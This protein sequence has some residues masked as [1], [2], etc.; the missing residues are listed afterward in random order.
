MISKS[1]SLNVFDLIWHCKSNSLQT[2]C[3][4]IVR[5]GV[6]HPVPATNRRE[7][8]RDRCTPW[9]GQGGLVV[10]VSDSK[11]LQISREYVYHIILYDVLYS[12][13][14]LSTCHNISHTNHVPSGARIV[15]KRGLRRISCELWDHAMCTLFAIVAIHLP[16]RHLVQFWLFIALGVA[17][18]L[19]TFQSN[20]W[21]VW[22][23]AVEKSTTS[24][25]LKESGLGPSWTCIV[26]VELLEP[27]SP[28]T[29]QGCTGPTGDYCL[30]IMIILR[31]NDLRYIHATCSI[32][33]SLGIVTRTWCR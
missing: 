13:H 30:E 5:Y 32:V 16:W 8:S 17:A 31:I 4:P 29:I 9:Q 21:T 15:K 6:G 12:Y 25:L 33:E 7:R 28:R 19:A 22:Y 20:R 3:E 27:N 2:R 14:I 1:K 23:S 18:L 24:W 26:I 10:F 11:Q